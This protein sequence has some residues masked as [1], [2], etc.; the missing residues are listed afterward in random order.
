[1]M[2]IRICLSELDIPFNGLVWSHFVLKCPFRGRSLL[3]QAPKP[4][5]LVEISEK[6]LT[7]DLRSVRLVTDSLVGLD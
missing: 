7:W 5:N 4:A 2:S 6:H 1:M 3:F